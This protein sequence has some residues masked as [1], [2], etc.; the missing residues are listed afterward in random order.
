VKRLE[1]RADLDI[2]YSAPDAAATPWDDARRVLES[3]EIYWITT[4]RADGRPHVTPLIAVWVD[5]ALYFGTGE[6]EQKAKN[7]MRNPGCALTTGC[8]LIGHGLDVVVEGA[9]VRVISERELR[10]IADAIVDKYGPEWRFDV[11]A[12]A[13]EGKQGNVAWLFRVQPS[14]V[15]GF[16]KGDPFS[17]TTWRF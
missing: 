11:R 3:A 9:A 1:P 10:R 5:D 16:G 8:N 2:R 14:T 17:Q 12:D 4:V 6:A 13:L 7:L 15:F